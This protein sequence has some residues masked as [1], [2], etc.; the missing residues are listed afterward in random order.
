MLKKIK[1]SQKQKKESKRR[2]EIAK[3]Y[4]DIEMYNGEIINEKEN[5]NE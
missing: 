3:V 4:Y 1:D 5:R 2:K